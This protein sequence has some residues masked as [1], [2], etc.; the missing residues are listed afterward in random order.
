MPIEDV[1]Y[2]RQNSIRQSY[3]FLVDSLD[4]NH[5]A[6]A[7]PSEYVVEFT[8]PFHNVIGMEV[9]D[10]SIPRT[11]YNVDITNN[12]ITIFIH[13][14]STNGFQYEKYVTVYVEP[15]DYTIQTLIPAMNSVLFMHLNGDTNA[16]VQNITVEAVSNPPEVKSVLRFRCPYKFAIDMSRSTIA[17]TVG[18]DMY[19]QTSEALKAP[20]DQRYTFADPVLHPRVYHSVDVDSSVALGNERTVFEGPR[21]VVRRLQFATA[22]TQIAQQFT[23]TSPGYLTQ[24]FTALTTTDGTITST[25][26]ARW[27]L[28]TN[29]NNS[30]GTEIPLV[31]KDG[32]P[33]NGTIPISISNGAYSDLEMTV[34]VFLN[35]GTYW[36]VYASDSA[37]NYIYYNDV[38]TLQSNGLAKMRSSL[39]AS[40]QEIR[41]DDIHF[42]LSIKVVMQDSYHVLT[43]PGIYSLVG[44]PYV[45]L[46]CPEIEE[47]AFRSLAYSRHC[48]GLAKFRL[49]VVG[50]SENRVDFNKVPTR[51]FHPIGKLSRIS[52]RFETR[53]GR[54]Y[55]FKG[56][57]HTITFA[58]H[59]LEPKQNKT[60]HRSILNPNYSADVMEYMFQQQ[61]DDSDDQD[62]EYSKDTL[63]DYRLQESR[64]FPE[65]IR[66]MD[67][68]A[69]YRMRELYASDGSE[70]S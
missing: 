15:G 31:D 23:I 18:F 28:Y 65:N 68:E 66:R 59:Y 36:I 52:L 33:D 54:L 19:V 45:V 21:G 67:A 62:Y 51:E 40:W 47:N 43:A 38:P 3:I 69:L 55:D 56:V 70:S 14:N 10:A 5:Q 29:Q 12:S 35:P 26:V 6:Y 61:E 46:R 2:L 22:T 9:L 60:F 8:T 57:N 32:N 48:L 42:E 16:S 53:S 63:T 11:E 49:G 34:Q 58:I 20:L 27:K 30:P 37:D 13:D 24:V 4:R 1:D 25:S 64:H 39:Q 44:E 17:E 41:D 7:T 50:Y